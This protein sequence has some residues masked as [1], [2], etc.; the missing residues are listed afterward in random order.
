MTMQAGFGTDNWPKGFAMP[1]EAAER[2][3]K[4]KKTGVLP[5]HLPEGHYLVEKNDK[6]NNKDKKYNRLDYYSQ[7]IK[8]IFRY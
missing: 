7:K 2:I 3:K 8:E 4:Y 6:E 1:L 5:I